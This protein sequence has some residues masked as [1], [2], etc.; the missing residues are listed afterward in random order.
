MLSTALQELLDVASMLCDIAVVDHNIVNYAAVSRQTSECFIYSMIVV[1][2]Y[3]G[4]SVGGT[5]VLERIFPTA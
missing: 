5:E 1:L 3:G 4:D 2:R